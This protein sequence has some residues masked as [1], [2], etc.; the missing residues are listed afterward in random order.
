MCIRD[1]DTWPRRPLWGYVD[2]ADPRVMEME[3]DAAADYGVNV[4]IYDW[5][6]F[7]QRPFLNQC[8]ERGYLKAVS[9]THLIRGH[10]LCSSLQK[11]ISRTRSRWLPVMPIRIFPCRCV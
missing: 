5:Y 3:I 8:L 4:F 6:W 1:R 11:Q 2:E 7:D 10:S 9:Y